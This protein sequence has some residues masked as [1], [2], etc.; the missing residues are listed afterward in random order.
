MANVNAMTGPVDQATHQRSSRPRAGRKKPAKKLEVDDFLI[1]GAKVHANLTGL[2]NK[3]LTLTLPDIHLT[4]LGKGPDGI[5]AADLTKK[6]L[7]AITV[8][9]I[10]ALAKTRR[11]P[12]QERGQGRARCRQWRA[13]KLEQ[14]RG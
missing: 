3:E 14:W 12:G 1:T 11:Q 13:A 5:T 6:V 8:N 4:D 9:T 7:T 10:T 2:V